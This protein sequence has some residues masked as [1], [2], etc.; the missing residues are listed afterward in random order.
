MLVVWIARHIG[1]FR[2]A[3]H[4][5]HWT[6][7]SLSRLIFVFARRLQRAR[8]R[9]LYMFT[10]I[11]L[12]LT[13]I[14]FSRVRSR[15]AEILQNFLLRIVFTLYTHTQSQYTFLRGKYFLIA[16][17]FPPRKILRRACSSLTHDTQKFIHS[18][19]QWIYFFGWDNIFLAD[20]FWVALLARNRTVFETLLISGGYGA[21]PTS[22]LSAAC[23]TSVET[24]KSKFYAQIFP[25]KAHQLEWGYALNLNISVSA[26]Q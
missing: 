10:C 26:A 16:N 14:F 23:F 17:I 22:L 8:L 6:F 15:R 24:A 20:R 7:I 2:A 3:E 18:H 21:N 5:T 25:I 13:H 1:P 9:V 19:C 12:H 4:L 11:Y